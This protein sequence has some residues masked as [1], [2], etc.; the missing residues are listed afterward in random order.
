MSSMSRAAVSLAVFGSYLIVLG[1]LLAAVPNLVLGPFGFPPATDPWVHVL[2]CV[3]GT[4]GAYYV[5]AARQEVTPLF[6]R[7]V[8]GRAV[9]FVAFGVLVAAGVAPPMLVLFGATDLAA[10]AWTHL[11]LRAD[12]AALR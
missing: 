2:G 9:V 5:A 3:V 7:S 12:A 11:A 4:L 10:G 8:W 1:L 6:R